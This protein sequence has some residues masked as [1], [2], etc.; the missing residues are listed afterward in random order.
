ME[1]ARAADMAFVGRWFSPDVR[2]RVGQAVE[3]L[4]NRK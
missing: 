3:R 1:S 2:E 4:V